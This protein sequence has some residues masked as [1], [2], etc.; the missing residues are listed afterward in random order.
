MEHLNRIF[1]AGHQGMVGSAIVRRMQA[2]GMAPPILGDLAQVDLRDQ[3]STRR[4]L[5]QNRPTAL[6]IAAA[7]VG[8]I[9]ANRTQPAEFLYDNLA[10]AANLIDGAYRCGIRRVLFLGSSCIYPRLAP[11]PIA[12][13]S[14][15]TGPLEPTNAAYA[16]AKIV[17]LKLCEAYRRQYGVCFHSAMPT[18]LYG[19]CDNYDLETSHVLPAMIRKFDDAARSGARTVTL[20]GT[21]TPLRE[22]LH[23]DDVASG[24]LFLLRHPSPPDWVN[25]GSGCEVTIRQLAELVRD[26][27]G[28]T[29]ELA[30]DA[31]KPDGTPRKL[32]DCRLLHSLGWKPSLTLA[33]GIRQT[34]ACYREEKAAGRAR[35]V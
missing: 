12:E 26:A 8:G 24:L 17:G 3:A 20:W 9:E 21:G 11:Q 30:F 23:V 5:E 6:I 15:L 2:E 29:C 27:C 34:V 10:I 13:D 19:P 18:N 31:G 33:E 32:I 14:L 4:F 35:G 22:F 16:I 7:R 25:I 1:I 28:A